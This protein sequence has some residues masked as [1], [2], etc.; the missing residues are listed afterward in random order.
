MAARGAWEVVEAADRGLSRRRAVP[1][2][3]RAGD[4]H[5][6]AAF[7]RAT[8]GFGGDAAMSVPD[9]ADLGGALDRA[10]RAGGADAGRIRAATDSAA[11][12]AS[13]DG[14]EHGGGMGRAGVACGVAGDR[15]IKPGSVVV[16]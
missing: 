10:V 2:W 11:A 12:Q 8:L 4:L 14:T 9:G 15:D 3:T 6:V 7:E 13:P 5:G 1:A 16:R